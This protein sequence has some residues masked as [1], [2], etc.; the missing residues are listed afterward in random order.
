MDF[1]KKIFSKDEA[2]VPTPNQ[3]VTGI[4][5]IVVQAIENLFPNIDD[6]QYTF[7]YVLQLKEKGRTYHN[8][9]LLLAILFYSKGRIRNL[10][11]MKAVGE[12]YFMMDEIEPIFPKM[13]D[14]EEWVKSITKPQV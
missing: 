5:P 9:R 1:F 11:D 14:A 3:Q 4:P 13:K 8:P 10:L 7:Q 2:F 6:Q 12:Y